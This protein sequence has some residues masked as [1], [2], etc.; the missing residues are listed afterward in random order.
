VQ[1]KLKAAMENPAKLIREFK[2]DDENAGMES[3]QL[4]LL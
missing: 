3:E 2:A 1:D 4:P